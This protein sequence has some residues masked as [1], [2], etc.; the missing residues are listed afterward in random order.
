MVYR[1]ATSK[2]LL[3]QQN[4][5][6]LEYNVVTARNNTFLENLQKAK[7]VAVRE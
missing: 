5:R 4:G 7:N 2:A 6:E 3:M 1:P